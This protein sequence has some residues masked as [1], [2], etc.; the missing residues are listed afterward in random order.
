MAD[1][2]KTRPNDRSVKAFVDGVENEQRRKDTR[3]VMTIL[4]RVTGKAPKM[5][6]DAI[7][8]YDSYHY[9]Y[10][11]GRTG[12][13]PITGVSPRKQSLTL[14]IM[15]GFERYPQLMKK[16]GKHKTGKSCLYINKLEDV[17][18]GVLEELVAASVRHMR[19][20]HG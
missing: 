10:A 19:A 12:D 20:K 11:S 1:E 15:P 6:G 3:T 13:W 16:L 14:Y 17:D 5:W 8:G 4:R 7:I 9:V 2:A 18:L